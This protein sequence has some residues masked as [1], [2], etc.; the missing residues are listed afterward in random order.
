MAQVAQIVFFPS[1]GRAQG[2]E[3]MGRRPFFLRVR[4]RGDWLGGGGAI[5][6]PN[7]R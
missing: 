4:A 1:E 6:G 7:R 5:S 3:I 2:A